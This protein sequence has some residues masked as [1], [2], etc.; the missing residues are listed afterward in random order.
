MRDQLRQPCAG[1][2]DQ[3]VGRV[4]APVGAH[5]HAVAVRFPI[6]HLFVR[7]E[8]GAVRPGQPQVGGDAAFRV[9]EAAVRLQ[10]AG[11]LLRQS[12][13]REALA[14]LLAGEHLVGDVVFRQEASVPSTIS[15]PGRPISSDPVMCKQR[16]PEACSSS[17]Q[18]SYAR[19]SSGT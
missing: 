16:S 8:L 3:P 18:S 1:R 5:P 6:Q 19:R 10:D 12:V 9:Q 7:V 2:D 4:G 15:L 11:I 17:R 13:G 14:D